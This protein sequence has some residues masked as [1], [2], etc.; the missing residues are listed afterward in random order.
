MG[1]DILSLRQDTQYDLEIKKDRT[2][3]ATIIAVYMSGT[4]EVDF[5]FSSYSGATLE[6][7][8]DSRSSTIILSFTTLD[9]SIVLST[10]NTFQ[11]I[12][13]DEEL[14]TLPIGEFQYDMYLSST[15][16]PK[17]A[18]LSGKFIIVDRITK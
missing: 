13:S 3:A 10:G 16:Y 14:A 18:F 5:D 4:T 2:L 7:R 11:L 15:Q 9:G 1:Q 8:K 17:R 12:K 6:V